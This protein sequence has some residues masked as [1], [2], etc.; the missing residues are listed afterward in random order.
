MAGSSLR[1]RQVVLAVGCMIA[2]EAAGCGSGAVTGPDDTGSD[3]VVFALPVGNE[4]A[5][6]AASDAER[7]VYNALRD[8]CDEGQAALDEHW[9]EL[10]SERDVLLYQAA[11]E[12]CAGHPAAA[13]QFIEAA[14]TA[15]G[16]DGLQRARLTCSVFRAARGAVEQVEPR[17][18]PCAGGAAPT[19]PTDQSD[20]RDRV[21]PRRV[22]EDPAGPTTTSTTSTTP[23][24]TTTSSSTVPGTSEAPP[25]TS[26]V[27]TPQPPTAPTL[28]AQ[29]D[30]ATTG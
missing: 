10:P 27:P 28:P 17:S 22:V 8:G 1:S 25:T 29:Q 12:A 24:S 5:L 13:A 9:R 20:V 30:D 18:V 14:E 19:W 23:A 6:A 11:V 3:P 4:S 15:G 16:E 21:D 7:Q 26:P 2:L